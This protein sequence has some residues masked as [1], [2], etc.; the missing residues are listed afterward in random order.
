[1][2]TLSVKERLF[3]ALPAK[4]ALLVPFYDVN[5]LAS[6]YKWRFVHLFGERQAS[7][8]DDNML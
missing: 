4:Q 3:A 6:M 2:L 8:I 5:E 7:W 1:M